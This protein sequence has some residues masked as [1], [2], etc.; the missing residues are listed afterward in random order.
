MPQTPGGPSDRLVRLLYNAKHPLR[1]LSTEISLPEKF[2]QLLELQKI[3]YEIRRSR[4]D[5][6]QWW[7]KPWEVDPLEALHIGQ[8]QGT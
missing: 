2:R 8:S 6:L 3:V 5:E 1:K 4:G 7:E